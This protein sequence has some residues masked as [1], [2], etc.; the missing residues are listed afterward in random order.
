[1]KHAENYIKAINFYKDGECDSALNILNSIPNSFN[2]G[3]ALALKG[4]IYKIKNNHHQ[5]YDALKIYLKNNKNNEIFKIYLDLLLDLNYIEEFSMH[6][7]KNSDL[8]LITKEIRKDILL[9]QIDLAE[10]KINNTQKNDDLIYLS[11]LID[12]EKGKFDI[13]F[14]NYKYRFKSD[15]SQVKYNNLYA[16]LPEWNGCKAKN[17]LIWGEQGI[18]DQIFFSRFIFEIIELVENIYLLVSPKIKNLVKSL[19]QDTNVNVIDNA[20]DIKKYDF[21]LP[22]GCVPIFV[23]DFNQVSKI[24]IKNDQKF[25][26]KNIG[27]SW[28]ST[29]PTEGIFRSV[30]PYLLPNIKCK[31]SCLINLQFGTVSNDIDAIKS[32]GNNFFYNEKI[33]YDDDI[34]SVVNEILNCSYVIT[35]PNTIAHIAGL[36]NVKTYLLNPRG[37]GSFWY[38]RNISENENFW[39]RNII[40]IEVNNDLDKIDKINNLIKINEVNDAIK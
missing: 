19:F 31:K 4:L 38:W 12:L 40:N 2:N 9:D 37:R 17:L 35:V 29:N 20:I 24:Y 13:G 25:L 15:L 8:D 30:S 11:S 3:V 36:L 5:A 1:M 39:Y 21:Q 16:S 14:R 32:S 28:K 26:K 27:F 22:I 6:I 23:N 33:N 7:N 34:D 18:G 10:K